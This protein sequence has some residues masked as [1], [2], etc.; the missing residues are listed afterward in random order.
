M[1][2]KTNQEE[3]WPAGQ[4]LGGLLSCLRL[5]QCAAAQSIVPEAAQQ[6]VWF[7]LQKERLKTDGLN[8]LLNEL[9]SNLESADTT[10][11]VTPERKCWRYRVRCW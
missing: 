4:L 11:E 9:Q 3:L 7:V 10:D 6:K 8:A 1:D 2:C 5:P